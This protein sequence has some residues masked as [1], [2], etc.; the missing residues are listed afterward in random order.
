[1]NTTIEVSLFII[2][3]VGVIA[4]GIWK[5]KDGDD[6]THKKGAA[7]YFL[8]Q[9]VKLD[10]DHYA[11]KIEL[12]HHIIVFSMKS[13]QSTGT[14]ATKVLS[15]KVAAFKELYLHHEHSHGGHH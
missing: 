13:K 9:R 12:L 10:A 1:M 4:L 8:A 5:S 14:D 6:E 2:A 11:E 3:V 7:N 15:E